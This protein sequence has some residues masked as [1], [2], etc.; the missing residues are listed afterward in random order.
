MAKLIAKTY[1]D[2]L[3]ELAVEEGK[4]AEFLHEFTVIRDTLLINPDFDRLMNH[5]KILKEEKIEILLNVFK[6]RVS[7]EMTGFLELLIVKDRFG[8]IKTIF[9]CFA[10]M[11]KASLGIGVAYV[12]TAYTITEIQKSEI[13]EQL[14]LSTEF[15]KMEMNFTVDEKLIGGMVIRIGDRVVDSSIS[16]NLNSLKKQLHSVQL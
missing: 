2:A 14:I 7:D 9:D 4:T 13:M 16:S 8:E 10:A 3:F 11:V 15:K 12:T 5:P 1:G 6:G